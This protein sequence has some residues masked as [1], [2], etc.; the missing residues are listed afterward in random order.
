MKKWFYVLAGCLMG[1]MLKKKVDER[2]RPGPVRD[3]PHRQN[4]A[5]HKHTP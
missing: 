1:F 2:T 5:R 3:L 4:G